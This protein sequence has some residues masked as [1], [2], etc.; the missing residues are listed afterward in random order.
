M[1][2]NTQFANNDQKLVEN[3][4]IDQILWELDTSSFI[5]TCTLFSNNSELLGSVS[6]EFSEKVLGVSNGLSLEV[7]SIQGQIETFDLFEINFYRECV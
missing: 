3:K 4:E 5:F 7:N 2:S 1:L 6:D